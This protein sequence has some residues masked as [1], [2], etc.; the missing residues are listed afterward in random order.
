MRALILAAGLGTRLRPLTLARAKAA[1]PV[2]GIPIVRRVISWLVAQGCRDLVLN[3]HHRPASIAAVVGDGA[4]LGAVV[5]YSWEDP[6]LGSGGGPRHALPLLLDGGAGRSSADGTFLIVNGDT[7]TDLALPEL[8][9]SHRTSG[10]L[11]TMALTP[12]P[13]PDAYGGVLVEGGRVVGFTGRGTSRESF[14]FIGIQATEARA[15]WP[16]DDGVRAET[17]MQ[18]Y[19]RLIRENAAAINAHIANASFRDVGTPADYLRTSVEFAGSEGDALVSRR[20][21]AI[22]PSAELRHTA[23]WDGVRI[24]PGTLLDECIVCDDVDV[25]AGSR[26]RRS[27]IARDRGDALAP[28]ERL[29]GS[30]VVKGF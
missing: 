12:N 4:D 29:E 30:L 9:D 2:N 11:V 14:H 25:P 16:L 3:L 6:V 10:A 13:R 20:N 23:V 1:V 15:F 5:R 28:G 19:P 18:L 7:L 22:D 27:A 24:G 8:I 26:Y 21:V 17:V